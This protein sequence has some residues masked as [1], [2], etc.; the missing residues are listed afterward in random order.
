MCPHCGHGKSNVTETRR[1]EAETW[2]RRKCYACKKNFISRE[3][4]DAELKFPEELTAVSLARLRKAHRKIV[5]PD[6]HGA[7]SGFRGWLK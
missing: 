1:L 6:A 7:T 2:R 3:H 4:A 5:P